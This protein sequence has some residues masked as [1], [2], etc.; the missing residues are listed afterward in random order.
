MSPRD[1]EHMSGE[2]RIAEADARECYV[3]GMEMLIGAVQE[4]SMARDLVAVQRVVR[5]TA[6]AL[7]GADGAGDILLRSFAGVL[8]DTFRESDVVARVGGDEFCVFGAELN[9]NPEVL[10]ARLDYNIAQFNAQ[11]PDLAPLS[12]TAGV[13]RCPFGRDESLDSPIAHADQA[14]YERRRARRKNGLASAS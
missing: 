1:G 13:W 2:Q 12:T 14:M 4:L 10:L 11:H 5:T 3:L 8:T 6:R 7:C 9:L